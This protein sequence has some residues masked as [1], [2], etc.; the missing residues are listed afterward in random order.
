MRA[1]VCSRLDG[2][3]ALEVGDLPAPELGP[4]QIRVGVAAA[5]VNFP[6]LLIIRG[7]YQDQPP[8][9]FAPGMEVAGTVREVADDVTGFAPGDL[10]TGFVGHG[11]YAEEVV[12][13]AARFSPIPAGTAVEEAAAFPIVFGTSYHALVDR[14]ALQAGETLL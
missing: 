4:G 8:L 7:L 6:D 13:P 3:D 14:A 11:G 10:V 5:G 9:P 12:A 1:L 2:L